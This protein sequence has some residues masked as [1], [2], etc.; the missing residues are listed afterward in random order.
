MKI[1]RRFRE[2]YVDLASRT[3][4]VVLATLVIGP[5]ITGKAGLNIVT[6]G[7]IIF[8]FCIGLGSFITSGM[9]D[10]KNGRS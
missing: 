8:L 4:Q 5:F 1:T 10:G 3:A 7:G 9:E 6:Y 2:F